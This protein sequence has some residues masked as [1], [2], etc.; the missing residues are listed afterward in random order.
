MRADA[1]ITRTASPVAPAPSGAVRGLTR[2][3]IMP[4]VDTLA[5]SAQSGSRAG[6]PLHERVL[7]ARGIAPD[8]RE[9][10]LNTKLTHL[11]DPSL[12]PDLDRAAQRLLDA[13]RARE[14]IVIYG[15][16]DVDGVTA[17]A[18]LHH[19]FA[20]LAPGAPV[21]SY[22]PHRLD[23]GY[24][25]N[26]AAVRELAGAGAKVIVSVDCGVT[27]TREAEVARELGV[28]LII[29][30]HHNP[31]T[32]VEEMPNAF[33]V[34]HPRRP[35]STY[36]YGELCGAGVAYK[37][38]WRMFT[39]AAGSS[40]VGAP[41]RELLVDML[42]FAALGTIADVAPLTGE[43]RVIVRAGLGR[44]RSSPVVGLRALVRASRL[45]GDRVNE[46]D[47]GFRLAPRLNASGRMGHAALAVE[48]FT[49]DDEAR[50]EAISEELEAANQSRRATERAIVESACA[51]A[52]QAGMTRDD[53]RAIVLAHPDWHAG[54]VGIACSRLVE[55]FGRPTILMQSRD[56]A[57][58]G[59][60]RSVEGFN[61]HAALG[62]CA[63]HL[64][65]FGGHDMAAGLRVDERNLAAFV[66]AFVAHANAH[67]RADELVC[68][69]RVDCVASLDEL[70]LREARE[71]ERLAPFGRGNPGVHVLVPGARLTSV[72]PLGKGGEHLAL[73]L[74]QRD[75]RGSETSVRCVAWGWGEHRPLLSPGMIVDA[76][77]RPEVSRY[78]GRE[79]V[80]GQVM[81]IRIGSRVGVAG[82]TPRGP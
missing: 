63:V 16:Y 1:D 18:I 81:D 75:A 6:V 74:T 71:L 56:G 78:A 76:V 53:R 58:H 26:E 42:A 66:E 29:T 57:C 59:S 23:E 72:Q 43:N 61:L 37:L 38:A 30:D 15:D 34:V 80:Q 27:A 41:E 35:D 73:V 11:H 46:W 3:W 10:F 14:P 51:M 25:L 17:T 31:P 5:A 68:R 2:R 40:R 13:L 21:R 45:D 67:L 7:D 8:Q 82:P 65:K 77:V 64:E 55:R 12:I 39:L 44:V 33:A 9:A 52:E 22:V 49:T 19:S 4:S 20:R 48:L 32:R 62:A 70:T 54:V 60:G 47:V 24:G 36:P 79:S 69:L 50:A 28:D